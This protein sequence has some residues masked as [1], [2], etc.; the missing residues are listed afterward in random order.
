[1]EEFTNPSSTD[2]M[3]EAILI[4]F[5]LIVRAIEKRKIKKAL[6]EI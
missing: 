5:G 3:R 1:M 2:L 6:K 4:I